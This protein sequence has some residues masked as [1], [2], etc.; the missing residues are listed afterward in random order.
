MD[1]EKLAILFNT[2]MVIKTHKD[3]QHA[4]DYMKFINNVKAYMVLN[5]PEKQK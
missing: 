2:P 5:K 3:N 1:E 4:K